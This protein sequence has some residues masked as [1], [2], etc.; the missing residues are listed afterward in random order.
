MAG[1]IITVTHRRDN[2]IF[3]NRRIEL[4]DYGVAKELIHTLKELNKTLKSI[5]KSLTS[6]AEVHGSAPTPEPDG[7]CDHV[8]RDYDRPKCTSPSW[9]LYKEPSGGG[10]ACNRYRGA[11]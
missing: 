3:R 7:E 4:M 11:E 6:L 10:Y 9:C 5:D 8:D 1:Y 2:R